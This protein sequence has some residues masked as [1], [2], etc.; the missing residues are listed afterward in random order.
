MGTSLLEKTKIEAMPLLVAIILAWRASLG[1]EGRAR[2]WGKARQRGSS[3]DG[4]QQK[5]EEKKKENIGRN[6]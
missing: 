1:L 5:E 6:G 2:R 3:V 4:A